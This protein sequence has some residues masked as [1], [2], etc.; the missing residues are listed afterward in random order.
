MSINTS[1]DS[2]NDLLLVEKVISS[3]NLNW[4][5]RKVNLIA[6]DF[7][8]ENYSQAYYKAL[9]IVLASFVL[10]DFTSLPKYEKE[11][12]EVMVIESL[13][14]NGQQMIFPV[15]FLFRHYLEVSIKHIIFRISRYLYYFPEKFSSHNLK[16]LY[17]KLK[18]L[19]DK[20]NA[21]L[22]K[23]K[24]PDEFNDLDEIIENFN[25][26]DKGSFSFRYP[27]NKKNIPS[28]Q[29]DFSIDILNLA[30]SLKIVH[31]LF[32]KMI[33]KI[34]NLEEERVEEEFEIDELSTF[35]VVDYAA[36]DY[37]KYF[38]DDE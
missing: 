31:S 18:E 12:E 16:A 1:N 9:N 7:N 15:V 27:C 17:N 20:L 29:H 36:E 11:T 35:D 28:F 8:W 6:E 26:F 34:E 21:E 32:R 3:L 22:Y 5:A 37:T 25:D 14:L 10:E 33:S 4:E 23:N 38:G 13:W 2:E 24:I 19:N 30:T